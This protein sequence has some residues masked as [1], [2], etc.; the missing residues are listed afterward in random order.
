MVL[1][2]KTSVRSAI[3]G[4][5]ADFPVEVLDS[6]E[7]VNELVRSVLHT[8]EEVDI[9]LIVSYGRKKLLCAMNIIF[10]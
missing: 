7:Q 4:L 5:V 10:S 1:A 6:L 2:L 3:M 8:K 9:P